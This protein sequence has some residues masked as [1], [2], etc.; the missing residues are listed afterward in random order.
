M[1]CAKIIRDRASIVLKGGTEE[2]IANVVT[3]GLPFSSP[4]ATFASNNFNE[5]KHKECLISL[6][7][8]ACVAMPEGL[9]EPLSDARAALGP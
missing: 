6:S 4:F 3:F 7:Q 1:R 2:Q 9:P 8:P 5:L